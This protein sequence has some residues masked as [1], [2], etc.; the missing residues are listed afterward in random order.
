MV[1]WI[2]SFGNAWKCT[3]VSTS[4]LPN[5][6]Y[7]LLLPHLKCRWRFSPK[8]SHRAKGGQ[9][10]GRCEGRS[11]SKRAFWICF[12]CKLKLPPQPP[13]DPTMKD[14]WRERPENWFHCFRFVNCSK[15]P[16]SLRSWLTKFG[17]Y[18]HK[19]KRKEYEPL[20]ISGFKPFVLSYLHFGQM[21][22]VHIALETIEMTVFFVSY[23]QSK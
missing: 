15:L 10:L 12:L 23:E 22:S 13:H 14:A 16:R 5:S 21:V 19:Q 2:S 1:P 8:Q 4:A 11:F 7:P 20:L 17:R 9:A 18:L 3:W 6:G